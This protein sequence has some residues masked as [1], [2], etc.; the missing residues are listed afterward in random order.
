MPLDTAADQLLLR[1]LLGVEENLNAFRVVELLA[2]L[3]GLCACV[4]LC[5]SRVLSHANLSFPDAASFSQQAGDIAR[6]LRRL[7]PLIGI[8]DAE[9]FTLNVRSSVLTFCFAG[10]VIVGVLNDG[11]PRNGLR[12]E[13]RLVSHELALII[14]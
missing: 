13:I 11:E 5:G 3:P 1:A 12:G 10:N 6:Q 9:T 7:A 14:G 2:T 8:D 4:C